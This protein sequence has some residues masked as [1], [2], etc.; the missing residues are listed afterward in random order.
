MARAR[1][2]F[3]CADLQAFFGAFF[4]YGVLA[5]YNV[6]QY[7]QQD[8]RKKITSQIF[9]TQELKQKIVFFWVVIQVLGI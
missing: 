8:H 6:T 3:E 5:E 1:Q 7:P 2:R 9:W 4:W